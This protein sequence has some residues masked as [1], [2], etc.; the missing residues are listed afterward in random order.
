M[1]ELDL[2]WIAIAVCVIVGGIEFARFYRD[3]ARR[4]A[5]HNIRLRNEAAERQEELDSL[6]AQLRAKK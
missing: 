6:K 3:H 4:V 2:L 1:I 5:A